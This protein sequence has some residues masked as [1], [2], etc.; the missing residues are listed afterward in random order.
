[1]LVDD[2]QDDNYFHR[3]IIDEMNITE[4]VEVISSGIQALD[5]LKKEGNIWPDIIFL[6]INMPRMSG[7]EFIEAYKELV[8]VQKEKVIVVMLTTSENP[9]DKKRKEQYS[10]IAEFNTKPL[11]EELLGKILAEYFSDLG[12]EGN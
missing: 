3:I 11:T 8:A 5:F 6:D 12:H 4:R 2:D 10:E 7:W 1:M 9:E